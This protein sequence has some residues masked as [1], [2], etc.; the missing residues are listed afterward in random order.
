VLQTE[1][2]LRYQTHDGK[3]QS[4]TLIFSLAAGEPAHNIPKP[5]RVTE[6]INSFSLQ[7][8]RRVLMDAGFPLKSFCR[9]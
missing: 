7:F 1:G 9:E 8:L 2:F 4:H 3:G 5:R 6:G